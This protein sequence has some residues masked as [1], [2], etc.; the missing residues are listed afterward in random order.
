MI[1]ERRQQQIKEE[2]D[3]YTDMALITELYNRIVER[4]T[5]DIVEDESEY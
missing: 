2:L 3:K 1:S 5:R 4:T